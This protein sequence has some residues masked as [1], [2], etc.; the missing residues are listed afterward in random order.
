YRPP[1]EDLDHR[2]NLMCPRLG[3]VGRR[4]Y[5]GFDVLSPLFDP[6]AAGW[7]FVPGP[8]TALLLGLG[9]VGLAV[10]RSAHTIKT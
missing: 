4:A 3:R 7:T 6:V 9:L 10:R 8:A 2:K 1:G 5:S